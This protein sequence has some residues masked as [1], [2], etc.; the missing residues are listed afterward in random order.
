MDFGNDLEV[1]GEV[2]TPEQVYIPDMAVSRTS[3]VHCM[4]SADSDSN[5]SRLGDSS[6]NCD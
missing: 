6:D 1:P 4:E 3:H 5:E 2:P